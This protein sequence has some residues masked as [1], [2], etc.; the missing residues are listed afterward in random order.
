MA[1]KWIVEE[2]MSVKVILTWHGGD[3]DQEG[4]ASRARPVHCTP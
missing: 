2:C 4:G 3:H 1:K